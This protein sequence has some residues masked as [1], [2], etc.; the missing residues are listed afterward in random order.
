MSSAIS[1]PESR[2]S[3]VRKGVGRHA[4]TVK[5]PIDRH[6]CCVLPTRYPAVLRFI[7]GGTPLRGNVKNTEGMS[8]LL[9]SMLDM[10]EGGGQNELLGF[11]CV[12]NEMQGKGRD[13][14]IH[15]WDSLSI[16]S[17]S[18]TRFAWFDRPRFA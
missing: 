2:G 5:L 3:E 8:W 13:G 6:T 18:I 7:G 1:S 9:S 12:K 10:I 16:R 15:T 14:I 17:R 11:L 4:I